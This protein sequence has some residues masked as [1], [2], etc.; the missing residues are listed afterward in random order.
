MG[1]NAPGA[2]VS[3][4]DFRFAG[5]VSRTRRI[6]YTSDSDDSDFAAGSPDEPFYIA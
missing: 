4:A 5:D 6:R 3:G 1:D 2:P